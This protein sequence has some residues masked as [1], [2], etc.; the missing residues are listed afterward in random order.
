MMPAQNS[1]MRSPEPMAPPKPQP[2]TPQMPSMPTAE[3]GG[4]EYDIPAFIRQ[5]MNK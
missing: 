2:S 5:R 4:S 3:D 1:M